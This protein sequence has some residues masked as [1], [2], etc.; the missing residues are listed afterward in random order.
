M[1]SE[2]PDT[3]APGDAEGLGLTVLGLTE[4]GLRCRGLRCWGLR[5]SAYSAGA[6]GAAVVRGSAEFG[7]AQRT[8]ARSSIAARASLCDA[9][10][11]HIW[12]PSGVAVCSTS[13]RLISR[14]SS[15]RKACS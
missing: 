15:S 14:P 10:T 12:R 3:R 8:R 6:C 9:Y 13:Q 2:G 11:S 7:G 4:L 1:L 5:C